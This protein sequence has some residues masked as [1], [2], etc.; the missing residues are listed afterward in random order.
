MESSDIGASLKIFDPVPLGHRLAIGF[1]TV[2]VLGLPSKVM[3]QA[4]EAGAS[5]AADLPR[6]TLREIVAGRNDTLTRISGRWVHAALAATPASRATAS[7]Q[8]A[9]TRSGITALTGQALAAERSYHVMGL[10]RRH[11]LTAA[12]RETLAA[13]RVSLPADSTRVRFDHLFRPRGEWIVDLHDA[14]LA[15]AQS[16]APQIGWGTVSRSLA[17]AHWLDPSDSLVEEAVPRALYGLTVLAATDSTAFRA[18]RSDLWRTDSV[19]ATAVLLLLAGYSESQSWLVNALRFFLTQPWIPSGAR[20]R[21]LADY[22]QDDW[23]RVGSSTAASTLPEI[24]PHLF[25]YPQAVPHYGVPPALFQRLVR[26]D[27]KSGRRWLD[28]HGEATLLRALRR[29]PAGDTSLVLLQT[30]SEAIRLTTVPRQSRESLNGFLEPGDAI[31]IDPGYSPLLAL[32]TVVHEWQHLIFR[33]QQLEAFTRGLP[34]RQAAVV[35]L[36]GIEPYLAEGFA[37]WSTERILAPVVARWPLLALGE[38]EKRAGLVQGNAEDHHAIGYAL[39]RALAAELPDPAST[40]RLLLRH[41]AQPSGLAGERALRR[42]WRA[43]AGKPDRVFP[44]PASRILVPEVTFTIED[45]VPDVVG[46]RILIPP[47]ASGA[48]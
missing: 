48:P 2:L 8:G 1:C 33:Q 9:A 5:D 38:L 7:Y 24:R 23:R 26:A 21:S 41:A 13:I 16:R 29:L 18:A 47:R 46:S 27:N 31:A 35:E 3:A 20:G 42:A 43:F 37:E 39:V 36:P 6:F 10:Y 11:E 25:G 12:A 15:W 44:V 30:G 19:A 32:G 28:Y 45:G 14:A 22:V 17:A 34:P 40:T 4:A